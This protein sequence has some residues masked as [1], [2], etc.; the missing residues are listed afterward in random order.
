MSCKDMLYRLV[1]SSKSVCVYHI[2]WLLPG[3][4]TG[5]G[6]VQWN[7]L[8]SGGFQAP[9][10][11]VSLFLF[12]CCLFYGVLSH[13]LFVVSLFGS[14][15][16]VCVFYI[17]L[18]VCVLSV[19]FCVFVVYLFVWW[20]CLFICDFSVCL[21]VV[22]VTGILISVKYLITPIQRILKEDWNVR[23]SIIKS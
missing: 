5:G 4:H 10:G 11:A 9:T 15:L 22:W 6:C 8:I 7:L 20:I 14:C 23:Y 12:V 1:L 21:C 13:C 3:V 2:F 17:C 19:C 16:F 18:F